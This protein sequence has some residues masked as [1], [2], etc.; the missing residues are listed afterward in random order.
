MRLLGAVVGAAG[1]LAVAGATAATT[2]VSPEAP[3]LLGVLAQLLGCSS[4]EE[5]ALL[6]R[7]LLDEAE[8]AV[9]LGA[10]WSETG[11]DQ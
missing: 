2:H 1:I 8:F 5:A 4:A 10:G 7:D 3:G 11:A 9:L 6:S